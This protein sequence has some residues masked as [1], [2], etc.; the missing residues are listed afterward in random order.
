MQEADVDSSSQFLPGWRFET[1]GKQVG[2]AV[3]MRVNEQ[4]D[5]R[6]SSPVPSDVAEVSP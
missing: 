3:Q 6:S 5:Y 2:V 4:R 1:P